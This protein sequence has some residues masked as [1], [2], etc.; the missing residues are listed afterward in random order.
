MVD[1]T[2]SPDDGAGQIVGLEQLEI[3]CVAELPPDGTWD[4]I[5]WTFGDGATAEGAAATHVY[6]DTG[7]FTVAI[8]LEGYEPAATDTGIESAADS[9]KAR[10]GY[11]SVC[12]EPEPEFTYLMVGG[13]DYVLENRT[14][15]SAHCLTELEWTVFEGTHVGGEPWRSFQ[16]WEPEFTLPDEGPW[17]I[18]LTVGGVAGT[19]SARLD[20][21]AKYRLTEELDLGLQGACDSSGPSRTGPAFGALPLALLLSR[22]RRR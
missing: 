5:R 15:V 12:G 10:Y 22:R 4:L 20:L 14:P 11:V 8:L 7:Q 13:L 17:T 21:D 19:R 6:E 18:V 2:C 16:T 9:Y 3:R 1:F